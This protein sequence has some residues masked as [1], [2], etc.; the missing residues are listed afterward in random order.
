MQKLFQYSFGLCILSLIL[1]SIY[2]AD[3]PVEFTR[4]TTGAYNVIFYLKIIQRS[5]SHW[6][7]I[8]PK[9]GGNIKKLN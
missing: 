3:M 8:N 4:L 6:F 5:S 7:K 1:Y 9:T 2:P